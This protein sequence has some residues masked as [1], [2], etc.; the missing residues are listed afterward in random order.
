M[1]LHRHCERSEAIQ[2]HDEAAIFFRVKRRFFQEIVARR[3]FYREAG[4]RKIFF[5]DDVARIKAALP[6]PSNS[7]R[8]AKARPRTTQFEG[9]TY[10]ATL[11]EL[12]ALLTSG[13]P[14]RGL[15]ASKSKSNVVNIGSR[16][17]SR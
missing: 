9:R 16:T 8:R 7:S 11:T 10:D 15:T 13:K 1:L 3:P 4:R 14:A 5:A 6:C 17:P 12:R 2:D